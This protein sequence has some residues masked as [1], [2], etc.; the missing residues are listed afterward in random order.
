VT[1][2][3]LY[4]ERP[5]KVHLHY[6]RTGQT[7]KGR[8]GKNRE[9]AHTLCAGNFAGS[10]L[11][12]TKKPHEVTC[13]VCLKHM[14][15]GVVPKARLSQVPESMLDDMAKDA[16]DLERWLEQEQAMADKMAAL[17]VYLLNQLGD[18]EHVIALA[19]PMFTVGDI[20][21]GQYALYREH[22]EA[23]KDRWNDDST[24]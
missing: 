18:N 5:R 23:R 10:G 24:S 8:G 19:S 7:Y 17:A 20:A 11:L 21:R 12:T 22:R 16:R 14:A 4:E 2:T 1:Y 15:A 6:D 13:K 9:Y 3:P